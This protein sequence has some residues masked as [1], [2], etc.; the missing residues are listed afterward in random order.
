M[1]RTAKIRVSGTDL[2]K[3]LWINPR[4]NTRGVDR[5]AAWDNGRNITPNSGAR[6]LELADIALG[7]KS[8]SP[9][10]KKASAVTHQVMA[11]TEPYS[12]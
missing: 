4:S 12:T 10:K 9:K 5:T 2:A 6:F 3:D 7:L 11:K 8:P 1:S